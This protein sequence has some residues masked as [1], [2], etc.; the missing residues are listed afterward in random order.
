MP[1]KFYYNLWR[2]IQAGKTWSGV[3]HNRRR[4][5]ELYWDDAKISPIK[6]TH[7]EITHY[8]GVQSDITDKKQI[9]QQL[10]RSQKMDALGKLTGGI[11]HD[12]NN[13]LNVIL[14]YTEL[15]EMVIGDDAGE[16]VQGFI[17]EIQHATERGSTLTKKL[18][19]FSRQESAEP[20]NVN[21]NQLLLDAQNMLE[22][23]L[24]ARIKIEFQMANS[25]WPVYLDK[26]D[27]EDAILNMC[28]NAMHSMPDG[29]D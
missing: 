4:N 26:G 10:R 6:N 12:Y 1:E 9:E 3:F 2:T 23:T 29:G 15:L 13:M 8:L 17:K 14:G 28:I 5:G 16:K 19:A 11:A 21:I 22:K 24:T 25:V 18:L 27:L 20:E 7:G